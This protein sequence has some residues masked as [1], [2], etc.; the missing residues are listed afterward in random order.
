MS[1]FIAWVLVAL[2]IVALAIIFINLTA[3]TGFEWWDD[4]ETERPP[5]SKLD[6]LRNL[7]VGLGAYAVFLGAIVAIR[8][9]DRIWP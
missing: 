6:F 8:Y 4:G 2:V 3:D 9:F 7:P 1:T 5:P